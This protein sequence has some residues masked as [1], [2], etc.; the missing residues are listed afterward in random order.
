MANP[1]PNPT[2]SPFRQL[3]VPRLYT[4][5]DPVFF[6]VS[7]RPIVDLEARD[8]DLQDQMTST[9]SVHQVYYVNAATGSDSNNGKTALTAFATIQKAV[10]YSP[11]HAR[12]IFTIHVEAGSYG[13]VNLFG[14]DDARRKGYTGTLILVAEGGQVVVTAPGPSADDAF[15]VKNARSVTFRGNWSFQSYGSQSAGLRVSD[16]SQVFLG[17]GV[18]DFDSCFVGLLVAKG[19]F[20]QAESGA[21]LAINAHD[22]P[23]SHGIS[24]V[25]FAGMNLSNANSVVIRA[26]DNAGDGIAMQFHS[27]LRVPAGS[28]EV[29]GNG[30]TGL[31]ISKWSGFFS[32][33]DVTTINNGSYGLNVLDHSEIDITGELVASY[34]GGSGINANLSS[35]VE[36]SG[37]MNILQNA[38]NGVVAKQKCTIDFYGTAIDSLSISLNSG[39]GVSL[40]ESS[41][42]RVTPGCLPV[43]DNNGLNGINIEQNSTCQL[44]G[45]VFRACDNIGYGVRVLACS[46]FIVGDDGGAGKASLNRNGK[47]ALSAEKGCT[48]ELGTKFEVIGND[49][50]DAAILALYNSQILAGRRATMGAPSGQVKG[51]QIGTA[52][53]TVN[54]QTGNLISGLTPG[55]YYAIEIFNGPF[56]Y[57]A[58]PST[59]FGPQYG[60]ELSNNGGTNWYETPPWCY[61]IEY[62]SGAYRRYWFQATTTSIRIRTHDP[63]PWYDNWG[64]L[65]WR[66][67]SVTYTTPGWSKGTS[68]SNG[69]LSIGDWAKGASIDTDPI[70]VKLETGDTISGL[71][72]GEL[73]ALEGKNGPWYDRGTLI[74]TASIPVTVE[75]GATI[76]GLTPGNY[77]CIEGSNG[78]WNDGTNDHYI[79]EVS[80]DGGT[81][82]YLPSAAPWVAYA[83]IFNPTGDG[84]QR[85]YFQATTTSIKIRVADTPGGFG[86]NTGTLDYTIYDAAA[87]YIYEISNDGGSNWYLPSAAPWVSKYE[88][89]NPTGDGYQRMYWLATTTS[90]KIRVADSPGD[91]ADNG[92]A[93]EWELFAAV[94]G[95]LGIQ[96]TGLV[97]GQLYAIEGS[98]G[99]WYHTAPSTGPDYR[100]QFSID[101]GVTWYGNLATATPAPWMGL[102]EEFAPGYS[103]VYWEATVTKIRVR[104]AEAAGNFA[105]DGGAIKWNLYNAFYTGALTGH[106]IH[107]NK[108]SNV[109]FAEIDLNGIPT[110]KY[111]V[112]VEDSSTIHFGDQPIAGGPTPGSSVVTVGAASAGI[113]ACYHSDVSVDKPMTI[114]KSS[115]IGVLL[116]TYGNFGFA[117]NITFDAGGTQYDDKSGSPPGGEYTFRN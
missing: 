58:Y 22:S 23:S 107:V 41:T 94:S 70:T 55:Q 34:N 3:T 27:I 18:Y 53:I 13:P 86:D 25:D 59:K 73:Y 85:M 67:F 24:L 2:K 62:Y 42:F 79:Y 29:D 84:Y 91:F 93:L 19:S 44:N 11:L 39:H 10:D 115:G 114:N 16:N 37:I 61:Q 35:S 31:S 54:A 45:G 77:Y 109:V 14:L 111:G 92:G 57:V 74:S 95:E 63:G 17:T 66:M 46:T 28:I 36:L 9:Y 26:L 101:G 43:F 106:G 49:S 50:T 47:T 15:T 88:T 8:C 110:G 75:A 65:S 4:P 89:F 71:V 7:N 20:V 69:D 48:I 38:G 103:R 76:S 33:A 105:N 81:T 32:V 52:A 12:A 64:T 6:E 56:W 100:F 5:D 98:N 113:F 112:F 80:D 116:R 30:D 40:S 82:W 87:H 108:T 60:A 99:P 72:V 96:I 102:Y 83:E 51:A 90:I 21:D 117:T 104:N 68:I 1:T 78:P 97:V